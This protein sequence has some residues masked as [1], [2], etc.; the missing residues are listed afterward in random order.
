MK[1]FKPYAFLGHTPLS[2]GRKVAMNKSP[3]CGKF[4]FFSFFLTHLIV[5]FISSV[6]GSILLPL[7]L[8]QDVESTSHQLLLE[9]TTSSDE[10]DSHVLTDISL[11]ASTTEGTVATQAIDEQSHTEDTQSEPKDP[12]NPLNDLSFVMLCIGLTSLVIAS[13]IIAMTARKSRNYI[14]LQEL[15]TTIS[16]PIYDQALSNLRTNDD[17]EI[18]TAIEAIHFEQIINDWPLPT[19]NT[20][21]VDQV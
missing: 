13:V 10:D 9:T 7:T 6:R 14:R 2:H 18:E 15:P 16:N 17:N 19:Q 4:V 3:F 1:Q 12:L 11:T 5:N 21:T 8:S 20:D